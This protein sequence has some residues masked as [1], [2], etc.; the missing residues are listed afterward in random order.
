MGALRDELVR[1][2][3][4]RNELVRLS[5]PRSEV[6]KLSLLR[7]ELVKGSKVR[8]ATCDQKSMNVNLQ[9][10][11]E[12]GY[13]ISGL[14]KKMVISTHDESFQILEN[15]RMCQLYDVCF[16]SNLGNKGFGISH[17]FSLILC[18]FGSLDLFGQRVL[19]NMCV[20]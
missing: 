8:M 20:I 17:H 6:V 4:L 5:P 7:N 12:Y 11:K 9:T 2:S 16:I 10:S 3:P 15:M 18:Y 14:Y 1:L 13:S 19:T